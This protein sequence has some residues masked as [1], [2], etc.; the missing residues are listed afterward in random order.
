MSNKQALKN[1]GRTSIWLGMLLGMLC[2][3]AAPAWSCQVLK[4]EVAERY[5]GPCESGLAQGYGTIYVGRVSYSG[6]FTKGVLS[7]PTEYVFSNG[8]AKAIEYFWD[9]SI[10]TKSKYETMV[11]AAA[12]PAWAEA[13]QSNTVAAYVQFIK[14]Y[15]QAPQ[16]AEA[17][18]QLYEFTK[19]TN[20]VAAY[21]QFVKDYPQ[22][23]LVSDAKA[24][25]TQQLKPLIEAAQSAYK[26]DEAKRLDAQFETAGMS[27]IFSYDNCLAEKKFHG[28]LTASNPQSMYLA[29]VKYE[30]EG[31]RGK[32]KKVYLT[33]MDRFSEHAMAVKAADRL[34][35]LND[36]LDVE[37]AQ[38]EAARAVEESNRRAGQEAADRAD[39]A[40]RD[41]CS[42]RY[43]CSSSCAGLTGGS[44]NRCEA[45]CRAQYSGC[46]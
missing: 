28:V 31:E 4:P 17:I 32:A 10:I 43:S 8:G 37:I 2:G 29:G 27:G 14:D 38:R 26:C 16:A 39:R 7:G 22:A 42:G 21:T 18:T 41:F 12:A 11:A 35:N 20:T 34:A 15:P 1:Q 30:N 25:I 36:V 6:V 24:Q 13:K 19:R 9:G 23:A 44:Y 45:S 5:E 3:Q 46:H 40:K 33:I